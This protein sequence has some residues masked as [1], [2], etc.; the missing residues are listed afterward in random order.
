VKVDLIVPTVAG[1]EESLE[2]CLASF[3]GFN[4][5][6]LR[7]FQTCGNAWQ[8]GL[9]RS[10]ADYL[11]LCADDIQ[12]VAED[13]WVQA[14]VEMID[15][16]KI[17]APIVYRPSGAIESAGGDM[18]ASGCLIDT[19]QPDQTP[20]DF[21]VMPFVSREQ[22]ERIGMIPSHMMC[23]VWVSHR[24]RQLG[25]ETYLCHAYELK[26]YREMTGRK[27]GTDP[28]DRQIFDHEMQKATKCES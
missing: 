19:I 17:P 8:N 26:H 10:D 15:Q 21:T 4:P 25:Y 18:N 13:G 16:G 3:P 7:G 5:I 23:D 28:L 24:G 2:R 22:I 1:R 11:L 20:V 27:P 14:C 6:V 9:R 12:C